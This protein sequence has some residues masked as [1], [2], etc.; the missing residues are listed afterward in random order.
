MRAVLFC[1][2]IALPVACGSS[3]GGGAASGD[4]GPDSTSSGSSG[5]SSS[6][7]SSG[8]DGSSVLPDGGIAPT[9]A[10]KSQGGK[11]PVQQPMFVRNIAAGETGW[12]SSPAV[13]D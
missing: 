2:A 7:T 11:A 9:T 13:Y 6:G 5:G 10:C 8:A 1:V 3:S 12:F 4:G